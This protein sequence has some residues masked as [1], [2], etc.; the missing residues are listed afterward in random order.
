MRCARPDP[1]RRRGIHAIRP[2]CATRTSTCSTGAPPTACWPRRCGAAAWRRRSDPV[3][4][5]PSRRRRRCARGSPGSRSSAAAP[6]SSSTLT[7]TIDP[8]G[9]DIGDSA[10]WRARPA[11]GARHDS[12]GAAGGGSS[13]PRLPLLSPRW[14]TPG[15]AMPSATTGSPWPATP[16]GHGAPGGRGRLARRA[17]ASLVPGEGAR[18]G[19]RPRASCSRPAGRR[20][21]GPRAQKRLERAYRR[22]RPTPED[23]VFFESFYGQS[24]SDNPLGIDAALAAARPQTTR[25]WS[26]V[27]GSVAVPDGARARHRGQPRVVARARRL[28]GAGRQRLAAQTVQA[29]AA[30]ARAADLARHHAQAPGAGSRPGSAHPHR[31]EA[32]ASALGCA[33][34][35][36]SV[37]RRDLPLGVRHA[38]PDLAGGLPAQRRVRRCLAHRR[39][40][41]AS[42]GLPDG[43]R[44][45]LYAPTWR[46]DRTE[47]VDYVDLASFAGEL[48]DDHVL[49]VRGHSRTLRYGA[50]PRGRP[51]HRRHQLPEH[52]RPAAGRRRASSPTT[53]RRCSTSSAPTSR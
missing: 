38:R 28:T 17:A 44:V 34:R 45:V 30:P 50:G 16:T 33:A 8:V 39:R 49:L 52:G 7:V 37:Q 5:V 36:E 41:A 53:P 24:S 27:D 32:R 46:D 6:R 51:P 23:A 25:Y 40:C 18:D 3:A 26:V 19:G 1:R 43:A 15:S 47:M 4:S 2:G 20:R 12:D 14:G 31:R 29:T 10:R 9:R 21:A 11:V 13:P 42:L 35:A 48:G 22:S